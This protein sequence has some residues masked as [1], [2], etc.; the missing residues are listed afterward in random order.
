MK[1]D[2]SNPMIA[3]DWGYYEILKDN[4]RSCYI[5]LITLFPGKCLPYSSHKKRDESWHVIN[6]NN[7]FVIGMSS[8]HKKFNTWSGDDIEIKRGIWHQMYNFDPINSVI[9]LVVSFGIDSVYSTED[10]QVM[11]NECIFKYEN[12]TR[13]VD[14]DLIKLKGVL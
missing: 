10:C 14:K 7:N 1:Q 4:E 8:D 2:K 13:V 3:T 5:K 9:F 11:M 12:G 6:K